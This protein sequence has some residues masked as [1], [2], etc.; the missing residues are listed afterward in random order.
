MEFTRSTH[1]VKGS[2]SFYVVVPIF[3]V[4]AHKMDKGYP[5]EITMIDNGDLLIRRPKK[6][7]LN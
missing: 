6:W 2:H 1:L 5:I 3:W 4:K 7:K